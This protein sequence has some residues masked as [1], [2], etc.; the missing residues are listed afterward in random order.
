MMEK[1]EPIKSIRCRKKSLLHGSEEHWKILPVEIDAQDGIHIVYEHQ[2]KSS[3]S[4]T[5]EGFENCGD[6]PPQVLRT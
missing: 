4:D 6:D 5:R 1:T 2:Q 3:P